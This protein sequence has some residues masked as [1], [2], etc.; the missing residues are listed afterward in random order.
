MEDDVDLSNYMDI[1]DDM[2]CKSAA[3]WNPKFDFEPGSDKT[4]ERSKLSSEF[5]L[6]LFDGYS[7]HVIST[8]LRRNCFSQLFDVHITQLTTY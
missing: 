1:D 4:K 5:H 8:L 6:I 7:I 2:E 3:S